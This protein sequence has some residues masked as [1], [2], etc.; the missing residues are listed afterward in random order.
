MKIYV[1]GHT[2]LVGSALT[3]EIQSRT[4]HEWLGAT[5]GELDLSDK[6]A[7]IE[8]VARNRPDAI[9]IA[10]ARVGGIGA[11]SNYPVEFLAE[12]L[13]IELNLT[14]AA[15]RAEI[16]RLLFLGSSCI[17]P[18]FATQPIKEEYL[19]TGTLEP[20]N[21]PYAL[22]K[23]AGL[24]LVA[25]YRKQHG[26]AWVSAMPC[27]I[28]GPGDNFDL[29]NGH[30]LPSL[31]R[32]IHEAKLDGA[33]GLALWGSGAPMREF[34]YSEDLATACLMLLEQNSN[35][36]LLNI[37]SGEEVSI[38]ELAA[39]IADVVGFEGEIFWDHSKPDGTPRKVLESSKIQDMGWRHQV[40]LREGIKRTY[41]WYLQNEDVLTRGRG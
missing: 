11:N 12:N 30:V 8:F 17:Y 23:I 26:L 18:K 21:E 9:I 33:A 31:I 13:A 3:R 5:R 2:G 37:G 41:D 22:A 4:E 38:R 1:A 34:L 40:T 16:P 35:E 28:Y 20:T 27:N 24:K 32:K 39:I 6:A 10:A 14:E 15:F 25:A 19:L 7:T 29:E 36:T